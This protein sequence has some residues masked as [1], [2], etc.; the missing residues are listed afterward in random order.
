M[1][2]HNRQVNKELLFEKLTYIRWVC[3]VSFRNF[4]GNWTN[5]GQKKRNVTA[6]K[7]S[8]WQYLKAMPLRKRTKSGLQLT[9]LLPRQKWSQ[10]TEN[11]QQQVLL[12]NE[13]K[14][15]MFESS[16]NNIYIGRREWD[17]T[18][19]FEIHPKWWNYEFR[20]ALPYLSEPPGKHLIVSCL[21]FSIT[22]TP[23]TLPAL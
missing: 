22:M 4:Q 14:F 20:K 11:Q 16:V 19:E 12:I 8:N 3:G 1:S 13:S 15:E 9:H 18:V 2:T 5:G 23:D 17:A 10:R 21:I 7:L 6:I